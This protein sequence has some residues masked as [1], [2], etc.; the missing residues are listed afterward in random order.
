MPGEMQ[1]FFSAM[2]AKF[3]ERATGKCHVCN[4]TGSVYESN[5]GD[6]FD[7]QEACSRCD[8]SGV[9]N[10]SLT[11]WK[12]YDTNFLVN[13]LLDEVTEFREALMDA[14]V[15]M[16][17]EF[18][19]SDAAADELLDIGNFAGFLWIKWKTLKEVHDAFAA[20]SRAED[21]LRVFKEVRKNLD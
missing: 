7:T 6:G 13:R 10:R 21:K 5:Y 1:Q 8:G 16:P 14:L 18:S 11:P 3:L 20:V 15:E 2:E 17:K 4:G 12:N 9:E 19:I